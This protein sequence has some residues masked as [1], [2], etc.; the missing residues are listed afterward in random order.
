[1]KKQFPKTLPL[2]LDKNLKII[3]LAKPKIFSLDTFLKAS[4]MFVIIL[5]LTCLC[6]YLFSTNPIDYKK[7]NIYITFCFFIVI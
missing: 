7:F 4:L 6:M 3:I 2:N 1:M 5:I